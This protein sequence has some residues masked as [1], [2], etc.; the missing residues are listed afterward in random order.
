[1]HSDI[2]YLTVSVFELFSL[3]F[4]GFLLRQ[5]GISINILFSAVQFIN[6]RIKVGTADAIIGTLLIVL[7]FTD[8]LLLISWVN[9]VVHECN[10]SAELLREC[11]TIVSGCKHQEELKQQLEFLALRLSCHRLRYKVFGL[12]KFNRKECL[13]G[14]FAISIYIT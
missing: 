3:P 9:R 2:Q 7:F 5:F 11:T 6:N 1:M 14:L 8:A 4:A 12:F 13:N 10:L